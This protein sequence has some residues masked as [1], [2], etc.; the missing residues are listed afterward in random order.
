MKL[1]TELKEARY[2]NN[3]DMFD[4]DGCAAVQ[5]DPEKLGGRATVGATRMD[6][7]GVLLNYGD[8]MTPEEISDHFGSDLE[9]IRII[10]KFAEARNFEATA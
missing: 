2:P 8:G 7:D 5:F 4:W 6:A 1:A 10:L 9:A 3:G